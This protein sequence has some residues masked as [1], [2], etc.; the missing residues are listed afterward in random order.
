MLLQSTIKSWASPLMRQNIIPKACA[1][2]KF[3]LL[4]SR[5]VSTMTEGV[6]FPTMSYQ[7]LQKPIRAF[8]SVICTTKELA[9]TMVELGVHVSVVTCLDSN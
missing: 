9:C 5:M 8:H 1:I 6:V 7:A 3:L 2:F 4:E